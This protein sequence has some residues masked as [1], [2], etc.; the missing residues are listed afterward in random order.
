RVFLAVARELRPDLCDLGIEIEQPAVSG[1]VCAKGGRALGA[2]K[3]DANRIVFPGFAIDGIA[4]A[5]EIDNGL[6][7]EGDRDAGAHFAAL[8]KIRD[9][10]VGN[11]GELRI[12]CTA[13]R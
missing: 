1:D 9:E 10:G 11:T 6:A 2:G 5:P 7:L 4:P 13:D 12:T 8:F 3:D